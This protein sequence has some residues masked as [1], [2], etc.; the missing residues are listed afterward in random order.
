LHRADEFR[1]SQK[2]QA[3]ARTERKR[4]IE[5]HPHDVARQHDR[6]RKAAGEQRE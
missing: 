2:K 3:S 6:Q 5:R 1:A 4:E